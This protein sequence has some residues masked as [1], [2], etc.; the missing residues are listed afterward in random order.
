MVGILYYR[1]KFYRASP[2][3]IILP[4]PWQEAVPARYARAREA[5]DRWTGQQP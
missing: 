5:L 4:G 3:T 2:I 1:F